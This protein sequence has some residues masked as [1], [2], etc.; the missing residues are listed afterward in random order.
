MLHRYVIS[1]ET[2]NLAARVL[3]DWASGT[4][5]GARPYS[6]WTEPRQR[7]VAHGINR[8]G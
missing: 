7:V 3:V 6:P 1:K 8:E 4:A 2:G 5:Q